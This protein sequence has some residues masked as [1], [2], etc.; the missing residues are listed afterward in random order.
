MNDRDLM[1]AIAD[2]V[3][4]KGLIRESDREEFLRVFDEEMKRVARH[5]ARRLAGSLPGL[6]GTPREKLS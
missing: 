3:V 4:E 2:R 1:N 6:I 5:T